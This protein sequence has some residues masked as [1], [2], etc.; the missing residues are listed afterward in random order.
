MRSGDV[1]VTVCYHGDWCCKQAV[2]PST[3]GA[4]R[5]CPLVWVMSGDMQ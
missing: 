5:L 3:T 2:Q 4:C 1:I